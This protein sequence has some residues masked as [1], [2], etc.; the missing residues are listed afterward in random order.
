MISKE[1]EADLLR[2]KK[3]NEDAKIE[4]SKGGKQRRREQMNAHIN[5][6]FMDI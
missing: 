4:E 2:N 5:I 3:Y 1:K 6:N